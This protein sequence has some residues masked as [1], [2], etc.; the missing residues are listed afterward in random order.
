MSLSLGQRI[1]ESLK[2]EI[3][4]TYLP[5]HWN[6]ALHNYSRWETDTVIKH[7]TDIEISCENLNLSALGIHQRK[8]YTCLLY[9]FSYDD[10]DPR[11][12]CDILNFKV[13]SY[14]CMLTKNENDLIWKIKHDA[15][16]TCRFLYKYKYSNSPNC[17]YCDELDDLTHIF[18]TCSRLSG[19][20]QLTQSL[21]C[22]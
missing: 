4:A 22:K 20:F 15:I 10:H 13:D 3:T 18:I 19:L 21:I 2:R 8:D 6:D 12:W 5:Q 17:N 16:P 7:M 9:W 14:D 1:F 11:V